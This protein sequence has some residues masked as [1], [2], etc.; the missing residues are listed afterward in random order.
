MVPSLVPSLVLPLG[1]AAVTQSLA[2]R[3]TAHA[4]AYQ[5]ARAREDIPHDKCHLC[6]LCIRGLRA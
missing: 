4:Q 2:F 5:H 6:I 3:T 1:P